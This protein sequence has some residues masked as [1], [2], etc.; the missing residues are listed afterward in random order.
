LK[1]EGGKLNYKAIKLLRELE[2]NGKK[3]V[4]NTLIPTVGELKKAAKL[5]EEYEKHI[6]PFTCGV[7]E[8]G[9]REG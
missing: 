1:L 8:E 4:H 3:N 9:G 6:A 7:T 5:V 2:T